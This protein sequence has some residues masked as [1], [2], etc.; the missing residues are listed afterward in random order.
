M[1]AKGIIVTVL[2]CILGGSLEAEVRP[3]RFVDGTQTSFSLD[4][5]DGDTLDNDA[6]FSARAETVGLKSPVLFGSGRSYPEAYQAAEILVGDALH[7]L[8]LA[9]WHVRAMNSYLLSKNADD[10]VKD[11]SMH[12]LWGEAP[13]DSDTLPF[14]GAYGSYLDQSFICPQS[15]EPTL[16]HIR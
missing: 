15:T 6:N 16:A 3:C 9:E 4:I 13:D 11:L 14:K 5:V 1:R 7:M 12:V 8:N 10:L 2:G